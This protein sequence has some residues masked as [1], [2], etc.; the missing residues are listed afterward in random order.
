[1]NNSPYAITKPK[2]TILWSLVGTLL[3]IAG[4]QKWLPSSTTEMLGFV[5]GAACVWLLTRENIW[6]WPIGIANAIFYLILFWQ[7]RLF[8]DSSLQI[9]YIATGILGWYWWLHG[10]K[11][12]K[13]LHVQRVGL[14]IAAILTVIGVMCTYLMFRYLVHIKDSAPFWDALTTVGSLVAQFMLTRKWIENWLVWMAVDV[15]YVALYASRNL[16]LT[17]IL[18]AIFFLMCVSGWFEW[19][20]QQKAPDNVDNKKISRFLKRKMEATS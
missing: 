4:W 14:P 13:E 18:Y 16:Y 6:N 12:K 3:V 11:Q 5:T 7:S 1:M 20:K 9:F 17:S 15:I 10:G 2:Q 19:K 8:A